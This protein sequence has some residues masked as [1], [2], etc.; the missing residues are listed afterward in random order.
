MPGL[1]ALNHFVLQTIW[2]AY[3]VKS[4]LNVA[5]IRLISLWLCHMCSIIPISWEAS[6]QGLQ[7]K[8]LVIHNLDFAKD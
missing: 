2:V 5:D 4:E 6:Y 1:N 3:I 8:A 7:N